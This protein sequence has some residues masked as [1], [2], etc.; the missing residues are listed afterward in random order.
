MSRGKVDSE[1]AKCTRNEAAHM[2]N[3]KATQ[4][5]AAIFAHGDLRA[6]ICSS[7]RPCGAAQSI[8]RYVVHA[9]KCS[10]SCR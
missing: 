5:A 10:K 7:P 6:F 9:S 4:V 3:S 1:S 2:C 8:L